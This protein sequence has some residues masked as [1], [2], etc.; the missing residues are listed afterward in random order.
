MPDNTEQRDTSPTIS[1][2]NLLG[3]LVGLGTLA[4]IGREPERPRVT[5]KILPQ[6]VKLFINHEG[7]PIALVTPDGNSV[8]Y[9]LDKMRETRDKSISLHEP[10]PIDAIKLSSLDIPDEV[11]VDELPQTVASSVSPAKPETL[12][13]PQDVLSSEELLQKGIEIIQAKSTNLY[14]RS[15]AFEKGEPLSGIRSTRRKMTIALLD[16]PIVN[17]AALS[18]PKYDSIRDYLTE[19]DYTNQINNF[20]QMSS[21]SSTDYL[22]R[23]R[24][25]TNEVSSDLK[26]QNPQTGLNAI[27]E[28]MLRCKEQSLLL[29]TLNEAELISV[30]ASGGFLG[31][32]AGGMYMTK[33][34]GHE[35]ILLA[36]GKA[37]PAV[38]HYTLYFTPNGEVKYKSSNL[39]SLMGNSKTFSSVSEEQTH[40]NPEDFKLNVGA[41]PGNP[42]SYPYGAQTPGQSLRH[43]ISHDK[44]VRQ[45]VPASYNEYDTDML[46]MD[47]IKSAWD[48]WVGSGYK[49]NSGYYFVFSLPDGGYILTQNQRPQSSTHSV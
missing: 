19:L 1:R 32:T 41:H 30:V 29:G 27:E 33:N 37:L 38:N 25:I 49:D 9:D 16:A 20:K 42:K 34:N 24:T 22:A 14:I 26:I 5:E 28:S 23:L 13:L 3:G 11:S 44:L 7:L 6:G 15:G 4:V 46:A 17:R 21:E 40:P 36:T 2:R 8:R 43:E 35:V 45:T 18:D 31:D 12:S 47:G 10:E 39:A 48:K